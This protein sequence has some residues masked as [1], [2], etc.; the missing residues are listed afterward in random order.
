VVGEDRRRAVLA[1]REP[2]SAGDMPQVAPGAA[3]APGATPVPAISA[4]VEPGHADAPDVAPAR[5][6]RLRS[7]PR[8]YAIMV[9]TAVASGHRSPHQVAGRQPRQ[10]GH[11][12][13]GRFPGHH[14]LHPELGGRLRPLPPVHLPL[15]GG[16][17][18]VAGYILVYGPRMGG[19]LLRLLASAASSGLDLQRHRPAHLGLGG[20]LHRLPLLAVPDLQRGRHGD[21]GGMLVV[22]YQLG[23]RND[24]VAS[25]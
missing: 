22:V 4:D 9:I 19:G 13:S 3:E 2:L 5:R 1:G 20:G 17:A 8:R 18:I 25:E 23:F 15:P 24:S 16:A 6:Q 21:R 14:P 7:K 10:A 11:P 12:G